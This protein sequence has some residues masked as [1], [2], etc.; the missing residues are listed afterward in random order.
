[1]NLIRS[2]SSDISTLTINQKSFN[3]FNLS[4]LSS[5]A[6]EIQNDW[7]L[8]FT[9][10]SQYIINRLINYRLPLSSVDWSKAN[11]TFC[12]LAQC[13]QNHKL[14]IEF[15]SCCEF[16]ECKVKYKLY[17]CEIEKIFEVYQR[18]NHYHIILPYYLDNTRGIDEF[19]HEKIIDYIKKDICAPKRILKD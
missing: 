5:N 12:D 14:N 10:K 2:A 8:I 16:A 4:D 15:R 13:H 7:N 6:K 9:S 17:H 11:Q 3:T 18:F 19:F 1:M